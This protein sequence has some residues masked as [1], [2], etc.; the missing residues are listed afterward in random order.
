MKLSRKLMMLLAV[1]L[2]FSLV[3]AACGDDDD[4]T[5]DAGSDDAAADAGSDDAAAD[6]GSDDYLGDGSLGTVVVEPGAQVQIRSLNAISGDVAF[7]GIPNQR[8]IEAAVADFGD[9]K[10]FEVTSGEG[11]D[12]LCSAEG[13]QAA[14]QQIVADEQVVGVIGTSCSG[15]AASAAPLISDAGLVMISG[16]NTSPSLTSNLNGEANENYRPGYYRTAHNDLY[17][18]AAMAAFVYNDLGLATAA[19]IHDGDPYTQG[20]AQAFADAFEALGGTVTGFTG[21]SKEDTD[22]VP[23]LTEVAA[24]SPEALFF[25]IFQPAGDFIA[26]QAPGV[27]GLESTQLLAADG[28]LTDGFMELPQSEGLY[29]SGPDVRFGT[30]TNQSTGKTAAEVLADYEAAHGEPPS[31]AFWGHS[32]D[33]AAMLLDA[34]EA[35]SYVDGDGNLVIDRAGVREALNGVS[36]YS[37]LIGTITCDDFGDCGS[38]K[39][40]VIEHTDSGDIEASKQ[41]VVFEYAP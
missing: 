2:S 10:G 41:A 24:D 1:L 31:A 4:D 9:I 13:G 11:L 37:G 32:Y 29:F 23:V 21:V 28:L 39:I 36:G 40:T 33:A 16:S 17:Q 6:A 38:Q 27:A 3:A 22:M 7:L 35:A 19:A 20:L 5:A 18:G 26:D 8:G 34:I 14:A 12:D 30:N 15:A 25:P